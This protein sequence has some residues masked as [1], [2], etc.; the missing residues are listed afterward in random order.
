[1]NSLADAGPVQGTEEGAAPIGFLVG[2]LPK[3]G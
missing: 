3:R 1:M 2:F